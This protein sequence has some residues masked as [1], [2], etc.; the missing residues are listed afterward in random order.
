MTKTLSISEIEQAINDIQSNVSEY[1]SKEDL[2]KHLTIIE[3][4]ETVE[5]TDKQTDKL[6][7]YKCRLELLGY[8][9]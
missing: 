8:S 5:L 6:L 1:C 7:H 9:L 3:L 4:L 2:P